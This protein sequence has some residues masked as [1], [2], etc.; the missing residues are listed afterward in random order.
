M[1]RDPRTIA[2]WR[3][4]CR[5]AES[6]L[7]ALQAGASGVAKEQ[8]RRHEQNLNSLKAQVWGA[9]DSNSPW[10]KQNNA[11]RHTIEAHIKTDARKR[12]AAKTLTRIAGIL[13][14]ALT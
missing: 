11:V 2:G 10:I 9:L 5:A 4:R 6:A 12:R 1:A 13:G 3:K 7:A 14:L 8:A